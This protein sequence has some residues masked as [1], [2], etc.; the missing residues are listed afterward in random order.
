MG[1]KVNF[2]GFKLESF[3]RWGALMYS[4][5]Y[6]FYKRLS[7]DLAKKKRDGVPAK[8][9]DDSLS[10]FHA[11]NGYLKGLDA[12][13][14]NVDSPNVRLLVSFNQKT[15]RSSQKMTC[16]AAFHDIE[17]DTCNANSLCIEQTI[18]Q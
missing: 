14:C 2:A 7:G 15:R 5:A 8:S 18:V 13:L 1:A 4:S 3:K 6:S 17:S 9:T 12:T 16:V 10:I 11:G